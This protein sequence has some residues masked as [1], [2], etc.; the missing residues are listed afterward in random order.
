MKKRI[1]LGCYEVPGWGGSSTVFYHLFEK[2]QRD[3]FDVTYINLITEEDARLLRRVFPGGFGNPRGLENTNTLI[4]QLPLC[5]M[6]QDLANLI[7]SLEPDLLFGFGSIATRLFEFVASGV[8]VIFMTAGSR[9]L[10][11]LIEIAAIKDFMGFQKSVHRGMAVPMPI[12]ALERE[13]VAQCDLIIANSPLIRFAYD[14]F[15]PSASGKIYSN[16]I[17]VADFTFAEADRFSHL[18]RPFAERDID[19]I[20]VASDWARP[21]KNYSLAKNIIGRCR[22]LNVHVVGKTD[23]RCLRARQHGVMVRREDLYGLLGRSKSLVCPSL[24]D[25]APGVLFEAGAMGCNVIASPNC[26]NWELCNEALVAESCCVGAF[27]RKIEMS[28][29]GPYEDHRDRFIG[30]YADLVE[31]LSAY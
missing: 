22:G 31:T 2:M 14:H 19:V 29:R 18:K 13:I 16:I 7:E 25:A 27:L 21:E 15:F 17:S 11:H 4:L 20:L 24:L 28:S 3:G 5:R 1:L 30:G 8:P 23:G 10:G 9:S 26:G 6:H 12:D